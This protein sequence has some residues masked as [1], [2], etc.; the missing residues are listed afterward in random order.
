VPHKLGPGHVDCCVDGLPAR[1]P[2]TGGRRALI[3]RCRASRRCDDDLVSVAPLRLKQGDLASRRANCS[4]TSSIIAN[5]ASDR[6]WI[7]RRSVSDCCAAKSATRSTSLRGGPTSARASS[8][9][10][11][12]RPPSAPLPWPL[13]LPLPL[14]RVAAPLFDHLTRAPPVPGSAAA[15]VEPATAG[16]HS[17]AVRGQ[18]GDFK[19]VPGKGARPVSSSQRPSAAIISRAWSLS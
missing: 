9:V 2:P 16:D 14:V 6:A 13:P 18:R 5:V 15:S 4:R 3:E 7:R 12:G 17:P 11:F 10:I 8:Q 19:G 1:L